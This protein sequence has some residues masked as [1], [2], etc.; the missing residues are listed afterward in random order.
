VRDRRPTR[1]VAIYSLLCHAPW[2]PAQSSQGISSR[3][4]RVNG[5]IL[6]WLNKVAPPP[7]GQSGVKP[8]RVAFGSGR[9]RACTGRPMLPPNHRAASLAKSHHAAVYQAPSERATLDR[10]AQASVVWSNASINQTTRAAE[11]VAVDQT[12][13]ILSI[14][15][16]KQLIRQQ[17]PP[18][19]AAMRLDCTMESGKARR[20]PRPHS[21]LSSDRV[22]SRT[23]RGQFERASSGTRAVRLSINVQHL[24]SM[25]DIHADLPSSTKPWL[26]STWKRDDKDL[27]GTVMCD[28]SSALYRERCRME[29]RST[30]H[31]III[32]LLLR[33]Q[34]RGRFPHAVADLRYRS[35]TVLSSVFSDVD[36]WL[37]RPRRFII[38][39]VV[40]AHALA[41]TR[42]LCQHSE[43]KRKCVWIVG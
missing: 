15:K 13:S 29:Y 9:R 37:F 7:V 30:L 6:P 18:Q 22:S 26:T 31:P 23:R 19:C 12:Q 20:S 38:S 5:T 34:D 32:I 10:V 41:I 14:E 28:G 24:T 3:R 39:I 4:L 17:K 11:A 36:S 2:Q 27:T 40:H 16:R 42:A 25:T 43:I 8:W 21:G 35:T 33:Q 1:L